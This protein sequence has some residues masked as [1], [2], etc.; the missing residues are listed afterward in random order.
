VIAGLALFGGAGSSSTL[1]LMHRTT[2]V[3]FLDLTP[4]AWSPRAHHH[5]V[6]SSPRLTGT[7]FAA[8]LGMPATRPSLATLVLAVVLLAATVACLSGRGSYL[9]GSA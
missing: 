9:V 1:T 8:R 6:G 5:R 3:R 2:H 7:S 4:E